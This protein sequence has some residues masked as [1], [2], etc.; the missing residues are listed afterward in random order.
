MSKISFKLRTAATNKNGEAPVSV[1][2]R[3][4]G[5][6]FVK[7]TGVS[8]RLA[9]FNLT[10]GRVKAAD[11]ASVEK[12]DQIQAVVSEVERAVREATAQ[13]L[14]PTA[15]A[16]TAEFD[17]Y[18]EV[19]AIV[20]AEAPADREYITDVVQRLEREI[21]KLQAVLEKKREQ[22][23]KARAYGVS[24]G[25]M[26]APAPANLLVNAV[27]QHQ[28][29]NKY[30]SVGWHRVTSHLIK[31]LQACRPQLRLE[32]VNLSDI[33][34]I[35]D[36]QV[37]EGY[38]NNSVRS[39]MG[40]LLSIYRNAADEAELNTKFLKKFKP[41]KELKNDNVLFLRPEQ[42]AELEALPLVRTQCV[43]RDQFLFL[44][45]TGIRHQDLARTNRAAVQEIEYT[46]N[47]KTW[48]QVELRLTTQK[49]G[50]AI[51]V[52]LSSR[53]QALLKKYE[54]IFTPIVNTYFN[55]IL[56]ALSSKANGMQKG[57]TVTH[58]TGNKGE[59]KSPPVHELIS[60][61]VGRK[62][63]INTCMLNNVPE[64]VVATWVG[65]EDLEMIYK[66]YSNRNAQ[67]AA[68]AHRI[69]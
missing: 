56:K 69:M 14:E 47:G 38:R 25:A 35:Q 1:V 17:R 12:N 7:A 57:H 26:E 39:F 68:A 60:S 6:D 30:R 24:W 32:D 49:V 41:L 29:L 21:S 16:V 44:C 22:L 50:K 13:G 19:Q 37:A 48:Q 64:G 18:R 33:N 8:V 66:H 10:A 40:K 31:I 20:A 15:A 27:R 59:S 4:K 52:P 9:W 62:T 23:E 55:R 53:A 45:D 5:S 42:L 61:H 46:E 43:V 11:V 67:A 34:A 3:C 2:H 36:F 54:Y 65:H 63:F 51:A 58:Y 28:E